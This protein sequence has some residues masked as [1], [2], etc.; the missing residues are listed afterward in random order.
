MNLTSSFIFFERLNKIEC[1]TA[2]KGKLDQ[3]TENKHVSDTKQSRG[4][5]QEEKGQEC[6]DDSDFV[7]ASSN[8]WI[9]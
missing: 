8:S 7:I 5:T 1:R 2:S 6:Y 4:M 9:G 3:N